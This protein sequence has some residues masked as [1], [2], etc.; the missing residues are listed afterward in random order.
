MKAKIILTKE[1]VD[2]L[3]SIEEKQLRAKFEKD[4]A[5]IRKKNHFLNTV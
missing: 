5:A 3:V 1:Q 2:E 4:L